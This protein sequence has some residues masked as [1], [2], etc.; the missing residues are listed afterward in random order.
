MQKR[1]DDAIFRLSRKEGVILKLLHDVQRELYGLEM[2][3][4]SKGRLKRGT[5]YV[6]LQRMEDKGLVESRE[7]ANTPEYIGIP[8]RL[9]KRTRMGERALQ[10][11]EIARQVMDG[12]VPT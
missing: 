3:K 8:R 11:A 9:Y 2:I 4:L 5:V 1:E 6:T 7:E 12:W 10:A